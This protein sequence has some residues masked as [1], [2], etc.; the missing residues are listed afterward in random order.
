MSFIKNARRVMRA[1]KK[2]ARTEL[3]MTIKLI[4]VGLILIGFIGYII[5]IIFS[6]VTSV[7]A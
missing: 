3:W 4:A 2:P 6:W 5:Q 1:A 7:L